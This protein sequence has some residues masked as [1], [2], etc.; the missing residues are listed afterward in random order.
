MTSMYQNFIKRTKMI[1]IC[2]HQNRRY[3]AEILP[4]RRKTLSNQSINQ[5]YIK[6]YIFVCLN[7]Y[8]INNIGGKEAHGPHRSPEKSINTYDLL[9]EN[10]MVLQSKNT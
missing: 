6:N 2:I 8:F 1:K 10:L 7:R 5:V 3:T 9:F 4:I